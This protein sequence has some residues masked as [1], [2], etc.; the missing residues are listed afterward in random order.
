M[1]GGLITIGAV[2]STATASSDGTTGK[3][4]GSTQMQ[5]MSIAGEQVT[6]NANGMQAD[7]QSTPLS[8]PISTINTLLNE[9]G[10]SMSVNNATDTVNGASASRTLHGLNFTIDLETLDAAANQ[11]ASLLPPSLT[12]QLPVALPN[13]QQLTLDLAAVQVS[14]TASPPSSPATAAT[15]R[16]RRRRRRAVDRPVLH[17]QL[18]QRA[19]PATRAARS[20]FADN[21]QHRL[22]TVGPE[23]AARPCSRPPDLGRR[24]AFKGIG[25]ALVL[26]GVLAAA[27][28]AFAY[29]RVD[30]ASDL[31]G[32]SSC[33]DG[34]PLLER[35]AA[36]ADDLSDFGGPPD[37]S[38]R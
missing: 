12:S 8:L 29:K 25:A 18:R 34:D 26:L 7:G 32:S 24:A 17:R 3:L 35:F 2:T 20:S 33:A 1:L 9:L 11:F 23:A 5:N 38:L 28:L 27:A 19:S 36:N 10:I 16:A 15:R 30:D 21:R 4:T 37:E 31:L 6:V 22:L 14:S 13:E